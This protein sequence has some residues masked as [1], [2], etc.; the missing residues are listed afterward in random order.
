MPDIIIVSAC[1]AGVNCRY[2]G[3]N[4]KVDAIEEM[5]LSGQALPVCPEVLGGLAIPRKPCE[6]QFNGSEKRVIS[7][8]GE[9][10]TCFFQSGAEKTLAIAKTI[11]ATT[12]ILKSRSPSCGVGKLYDGSYTGRLVDGDGFTAALFLRNNIQIFTEENFEVLLK[13]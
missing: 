10:A 2:N 4:G 8:T 12:A 11:G 1:L 13:E 5:V 7:I 3:T 9:D 6:I